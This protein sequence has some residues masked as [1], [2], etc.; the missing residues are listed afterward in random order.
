MDKERLEEIKRERDHAMKD[1]Y[2]GAPILD[3]NQTDW[4]IS[5]VEEQHKEIE[6]TKA[7]LNVKKAAWGAQGLMIRKLHEEN[8]RYREALEFYGDF[9]TYEL[10]VNISM[11]SAHP[12][13]EPIKYDKGEKARQALK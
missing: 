5:T 13:H 1:F 9:K 12:R 7:D 11:G 3:I 6:L 2:F 4:L 10:G 8:A